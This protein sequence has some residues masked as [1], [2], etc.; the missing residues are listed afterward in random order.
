M[1]K[2]ERIQKREEL[3]R[4]MLPAHI[5]RIIESLEQ[6]AFMDGYRYAVSLLQE[7]MGREES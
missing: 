4:L 6:E 7:S 1:T 2:K 5:M 3:E